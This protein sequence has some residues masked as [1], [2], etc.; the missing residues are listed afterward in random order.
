MDASGHETV[1]ANRIQSDLV[2]SLSFPGVVDWFLD[3]GWKSW[4]ESDDHELVDEIETWSELHEAQV[5][6]YGHDNLTLNVYLQQM[7]L[8]SKAPRAGPNA[9]RC[10]T[11]HGSKGLEFK[12][13]YLIGM[14][15]EVLP[16]FHALR[17]GHQ[18]QGTGR[19]A[20]ELL[21][22]DYPR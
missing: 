16:S 4:C 12:H 6:E 18:E 15:Q 13:V 11:V 21:C 14:A 20:Q 3:Q 8:V 5:S 22:G 2:D 1:I 9:V 7:D 19:R 17:K 10:M